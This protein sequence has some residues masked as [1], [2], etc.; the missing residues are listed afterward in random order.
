VK[1]SGEKSLDVWEEDGDPA[2]QFRISNVDE[3]M[4]FDCGDFE[5]K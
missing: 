1:K 4:A 3:M 2:V 5:L